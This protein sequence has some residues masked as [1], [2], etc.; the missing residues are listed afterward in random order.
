MTFDALGLGALDYLPCR[1][2]NSKLLFRGPK[3]DLDQPYVAFIGGT[4]TYGKF[5]AKPFPVLVEEEIGKT[6][7][8]FG[9]P[10]AGIDVFVNDSFILGA[11]AQADVAVIQVLGAQNMTN[12]FYAVHPRRNDRFVSASS[13][14]ATIYRE[15]DFADFHFTKHMLTRLLE[16]SP[17]RFATVL[18]ELQQAW[19]ARM[20]LMLSQVRGKSILLW[21]S[22]H[23]PRDSGRGPPQSIGNDPLFITRQMMDEVAGHATHV[24]EV[25]ASPRARVMGTE[26]MIF[27]EME[28]MAAEEMLGQQ[29][30]IEAADAVVSA[31]HRIL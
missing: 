29:A 22:E 20:R 24:V 15:V 18:Q 12:R 4:E 1:Y 10:N 8:N 2:G 31:L 19:L 26:G 23:K 27:A 7:A 14:L 5:L 11:A 9:V 13:L 16:V 28:A 25:V 30:H 21:F 17:D 3:R 6:A